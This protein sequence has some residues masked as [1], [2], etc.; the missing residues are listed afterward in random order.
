MPGG[1]GSCE[2]Q[3]LRSPPRPAGWRRGCVGR[4]RGEQAP[5]LGP[6]MPNDKVGLYPLCSGEPQQRAN[7]MKHHF[8]KTHVI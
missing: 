3:G 7:K 4:E 6:S 2:G 8:S 5:G 1:N